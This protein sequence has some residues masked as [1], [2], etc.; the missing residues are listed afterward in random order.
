M[1]RHL[2]GLTWLE[3]QDVLL[4]VQGEVDWLDRHGTQARRSRFRRLERVLEQRLENLERER[5]AA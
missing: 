3:L 5:R 1:K 4:A 2:I